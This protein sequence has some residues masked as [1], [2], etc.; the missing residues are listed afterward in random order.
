M[1]LGLRCADGMP[2]HSIVLPRYHLDQFLSPTL[3]LHLPC[4]PVNNISMPL[5]P[6]S[7]QVCSSCNA[8]LSVLTC[9]F[10]LSQAPHTQHA[11][12]MRPRQLIASL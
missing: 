5:W 11:H 2:K 1:L 3:Y 7:P 9:P 6:M 8:W 12:P 10:V 4:R